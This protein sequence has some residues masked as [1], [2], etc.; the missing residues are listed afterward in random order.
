MNFK[1]GFTLGLQMDHG[2]SFLFSGQYLFH[3]QMI[4][5]VKQPKDSS[6]FNFASYGSERLYNH[7]KSTYNRCKS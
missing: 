7:L 6:F 2:L 5:D 4:L 3:R 1:K